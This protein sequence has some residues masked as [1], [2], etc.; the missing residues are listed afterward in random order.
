MVY[1]DKNFIID[2]DYLPTVQTNMLRLMSSNIRVVQ[3]YLSEAKTKIDDH[4]IS[5]KIKKTYFILG[6]SFVLL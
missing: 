1:F 2:S 5:P 3:L 4:K 6:F